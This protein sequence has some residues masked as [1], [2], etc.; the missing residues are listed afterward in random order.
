MYWPRHGTYFGMDMPI[1][2]CQR[3][4]ENILLHGPVVG[5]FHREYAVHQKLHT[6][7]K[8]HAAQAKP[9]RTPGDMQYEAEKIH[10]F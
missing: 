10:K 1:G 2:F 8:Q 7:A 5:Q 6:H 3:F 9:Q 4:H